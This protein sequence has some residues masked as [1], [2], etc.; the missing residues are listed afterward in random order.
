MVIH[1]QDLVMRLNIMSL[2]CTYLLLVL[3]PLMDSEKFNMNMIL[4][5]LLVL[6]T[7]VI[8]RHDMIDIQ[9]V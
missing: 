9:L 5:L 6:T 2:D 7:T 1:G 8:T 4:Y 3:T